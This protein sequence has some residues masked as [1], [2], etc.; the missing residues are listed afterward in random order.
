MIE[1]NVKKLVNKVIKI[2]NAKVIRIGTNS[3]GF[4]IPKPFLVNGIID[5]SENY[6][7]ELTKVKK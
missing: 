7:I 6:N 2:N 5:E 4:T 1:V 3:K